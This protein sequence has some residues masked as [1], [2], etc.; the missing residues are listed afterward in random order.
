MHNMAIIRD[1]G[2]VI[3]GLAGGNISGDTDYG[4]RWRIV[5]PQQRYLVLTAD[6]LGPQGPC[7]SNLL[8]SFEISYGSRSIIYK[9]SCTGNVSKS[10]MFFLRSNIVNC[11][12]AS[13]KPR[14]HQMPVA[15]L[16]FK[17]LFK[18]TRQRLW[19]QM[20]PVRT[21]QK[22]GFVLSPGFD[23]TRSYGPFID[24]LCNITV[25]SRHVVMVSFPHFALLP[26]GKETALFGYPGFV[27]LSAISFVG[28]TEDEHTFYH[29]DNI[30][31]RLFHSAL[32]AVRFVSGD[33]A[34]LRHQKSGMNMSFSFHPSFA[35][36]R[37]L[38][39]GLFNCSVNHYSTFQQHLHCNLQQE[40]EG[41]EDE[42]A[43]CPFSSPPCKGWI[44]AGGKCYF[45]IDFDYTIPWQRART[46]CE[47][48][49]AKLAMMKTTR[50]W[51][52]FWKI[53]HITRNW[54]RAYVGLHLNPK[55]V[56]SVY[57]KTWTWL[58]GSPSFDVNV[59]AD[60]F[61]GDDFSNYN[62][63]VVVE[64]L[65]LKSNSFHNRKRFQCS[66]LICQLEYHKK[67]AV[68]HTSTDRLTATVSK[69][70]VKKLGL[71]QCPANHLVPDFLLCYADS[72]CGSELFKSHCSVP[73]KESRWSL[74][75][76]AM[77]NLSAVSI[78]L[79]ACEDKRATLPYT[80]VCDFVHDCSDQSDENFCVYRQTCREERQFRCKSG[81][82]TAFSHRCDRKVDCFDE[83]D[84]DMCATYFSRTG[85]DF[86]FLN[87]KAAPFIISYT[88]SG[89]YE[90]SPMNLSQ[91][92]PE[93][94]FRC[95]SSGYCLPVYFRCN[96]VHDCLHSE[97]ESGCE[98]YK[99]PGFFK[100]RGSLSCVSVSHICDGFAQ[101][102]MKDDEAFCDMSCPSS[103][104]CQ[105]LEVVCRNRFSANSFP[106]IR[107]LD[108]S[109]SLMTLS[110]LVANT[111]LV[112]I[113]LASCRIGQI[114][115]VT[116]PNLQVLDL[117]SN[118]I[119]SAN[120]DVFLSLK[121]LQSLRLMNNP[122]NSM[123][124]G[125]SD[126]IHFHLVHVDVSQTLL[127]AFTT[128][129]L[130]RFLALKSLNISYSHVAI[131][132]EK[133]FQPTPTLQH[134]DMRGNRVHSYPQDVFKRLLHLRLIYT[135]NYKLCCP[136]MLPGGSVEDLC[137]SPQNELSS[138]EDLLRSDV[139]R[140]FLWL[141]CI[142]SVMGNLGCIC[143]RH[144]I[145]KKRVPSGFNVFVSSL[146]LSDC[147]MG[148]F[149]AFVGVADQVYRGSYYLYE[150][151][152]ISSVPCS[153]A[154]VLSFLSSEVS[155]IT[156][157]FITLDR[158][159]ALRFPFS[160]LKL[161]RM[162]ASVACVLAW[163]VGLVLSVVPLFVP[164]WGFYSQTGICIPLPVTR[165]EFGGQAYS[166][167]VMIIFNFI[168]FLVIAL[169]QVFIYHSI[170]IN[171]MSTNM[172]Q[173]MHD[174][175]IAR[176]LLTVVVSDFLCWFPIGLLGLLASGGIPIPGEVNVAMAIF[177]LP[178]N[179]ALNPFLY[180][181][182]SLIE[183]QR[184]EKERQ[185]LKYLETIFE[186]DCA[187]ANDSDASG[188]LRRSEFPQYAEECNRFQRENTLHYLHRALD[189]HVVSTEQI[190]TFLL[191][192]TD[193]NE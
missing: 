95:P 109:H 186:S 99:C 16:Q 123:S 140:V 82:C 176:R 155:A 192:S 6:I 163:L 8:L 38:N 91:P 165:R 144:F 183:R 13:Q 168:L 126:E 180:T 4:C 178:L 67:F 83:S 49:G 64:G 158:F 142:S 121:Q 57:T 100:C 14:H 111:Y 175:T 118:S 94:Y 117:S 120:M 149:L 136:A 110:D 159:I 148:V 58:D 86:V 3:S 61:Y 128:E 97:D 184:N 37:V 15:L 190:R 139:Y 40:C 7:S 69:I 18:S 119:I 187:M 78:A 56:Y 51:E 87:K 143:F 63:S 185:V 43:H 25:P 76:G 174:V 101:C 166:F 116:L 141:I 135:S 152:W 133:G 31:P 102:P 182:N 173:K 12:C 70:E 23:V 79:F 160:T 193:V 2:G 9:M 181:F 132:T 33:C 54:K 48:K 24:A 138:C 150:D 81:Q 129:P 107:Y 96:E 71:V 131:I 41:G 66:R 85:Y 62:L 21:S 59:T 191:S 45:P 127:A 122:L 130:Q 124:G 80:L 32:F 151:M 27:R 65:L 50:E 30:S 20:T 169:G 170:R 188:S 39:N 29:T 177:I 105:G 106:S 53:P 88:Q 167:G 60:H 11:M 162:S 34:W 75:S 145:V 35:A 19:T 189:R 90:Q 17:I 46:A 114:T 44:E 22:T 179:S 103:C 5:V 108:A 28:V 92:C 72:H 68:E 146:S 125:R 26:T 172:N 77:R 93:Q 147:F 171:S 55:R 1:T 112:Y 161:S 164:R 157:C 84:E 153:L 137:F 47:K 42:G 10:P 74:T 36:P 134:I 154:G 52:A 104:Y 156:I 113:N 89:T 73:V 115:R 98:N